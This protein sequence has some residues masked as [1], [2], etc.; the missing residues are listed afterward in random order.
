MA[1]FLLGRYLFTSDDQAEALWDIA[2]QVCGYSHK[3]VKEF[4]NVRATL[5]RK[6]QSDAG[7]GFF[8]KRKLTSIG[9]T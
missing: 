7:Q 8:I 6:G 9:V 2:L 4:P 5:D 3:F 1:Y